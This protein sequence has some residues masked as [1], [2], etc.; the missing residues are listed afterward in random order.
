MLLR[1]LARA[2]F[3]SWFVAEGLSVVRHPSAHVAEARAALDATR[4][5]VPAEARTGAVGDVLDQHLSDRQLTTVVQVHGALLLAA[6]GALALGRAPRAA[7]LAL[8]ALTA[9]LVALYLP[10]KRL[11]GGDRERRRERTE[12]LVR[13]V[14]FTAGAVLVAAD[15]EG[16]PSLGW[17]VRH[18]IDERTA[19]RAS[20]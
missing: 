11:D 18:A 10:D 7:A 9:P 3:A 14:A 2:G 4:D 15:R 12:K 5:L 1:R 8:A 20:S 6:G 17:K 19:A 16:R 13:A